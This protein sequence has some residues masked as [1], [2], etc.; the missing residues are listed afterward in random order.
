MQF[1]QKNGAVAATWILA[2][3]LVGFVGNVS[4][5]GGAALVLVFGLV[6]PILMTLHWNTAV[7]ER[8]VQTP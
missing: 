4:S 7:P 1:Q 6:P 2:A 3:G 8:I 5:I